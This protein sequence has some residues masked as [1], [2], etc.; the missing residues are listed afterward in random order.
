M[1]TTKTLGDPLGDAVFAA[2]KAAGDSYLAANLPAGVTLTT[3]PKAIALGKAC[4]EAMGEILLDYVPGYGGTVTTAPNTGAG[5][6]LPVPSIVMQ[7]DGGGTFVALWWKSS[8]A[9]TTDWVA[10][11]GGGGTSI[12]LA[13][14]LPLEDNIADPGAYG[15]T[16]AT[17]E[18]HVHPDK[19]SAGGDL[20]LIDSTA[21]IPIVY[22]ASDVI[23]YEYANPRLVIAP[24]GVWDIGASPTVGADRRG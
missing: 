13:T 1:P 4:S 24:A 22:Y 15:G 6:D 7:V 18:F 16:V 5:V 21:A 23:P 12:T 10:I 8:N 20:Y 9:H 11:N 3:D 17:A 14:S 2:Q 19:D